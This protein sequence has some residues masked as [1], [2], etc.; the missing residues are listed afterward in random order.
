MSIEGYKVTFDEIVK[1]VNPAARGD[2]PYLKVEPGASDVALTRV[3]PDGEKTILVFVCDE[4][5]S[6]SR[7]YTLDQ[8]AIQRRYGSGTDR[9]IVV[10]DEDEDPE[11]PLRHDKTLFPNSLPMYFDAVDDEGNR[12]WLM[13]RHV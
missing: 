9:R 7:I 4:D 8:K 12:S 11:F 2:R 5:N 13:V 3:L 1:G 10:K 6:E